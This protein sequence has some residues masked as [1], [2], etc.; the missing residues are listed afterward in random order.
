MLVARQAGLVELAGQLADLA[1]SADGLPREATRFPVPRLRPA[2]GFRVDP[3]LIYGIARTGIGLRRRP[4]V[5][6]RRAAG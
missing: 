5:L 1:Q 4:A 6:L 3:A 2:G